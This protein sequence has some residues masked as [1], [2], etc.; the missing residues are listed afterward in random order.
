MHSPARRGFALLDVMVAVVILTTAGLALVL[1][2]RQSAVVV[3]RL[4]QHEARMIRASHALTYALTMGPRHVLRGG[5]IIPIGEFAVDL[6]PEGTGLSVVSVRELATGVI[7]LRTS[8]YLRTDN[9]PI[10]P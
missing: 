5:G 6:S 7:L 3:A 9:G 8:I 4:E 2:A 1:S 10:V